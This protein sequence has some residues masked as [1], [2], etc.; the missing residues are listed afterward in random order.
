MRRDIFRGLFWQG[1]TTLAARGLR[2]VSI[3]ILAG[4]LEPVHFGIFASLYVFIDG[5]YLIQGFGL[6]QALI[7]SRSDPEA[8]ADTAFWLTAAFGLAATLVAVAAA[9]AV[10]AFYREPGVAGPFTGLAFVLLLHALRVV[11]LRR[12]EKQLDFRAKLLP[13]ALGALTFL[14]V[15][16]LLARAGAG[17]WSF[18]AG[19][20]ASAAVETAGFWILSPWRP[21]L[22]FDRPVARDL[23][24]FGLPV[25][26]GA[27]LVYLFQ[28]IDR[29]ALGRLVG[30]EG[31]GPYAFALSLA[32]LPATIGSTVVNTVMMPSYAALDDRDRRRALFLRSAT[33]VGGA[34]VG[35]AAIVVALGPYCLRAAYGDKW[36]AA[37]LPLALLSV[38]SIGRALAL[39]VGEALVGIGQPRAYRRMNLVQLGVALPLIGLG[40]KLAGPAGV[41]VAM[42]LASFAALGYGWRAAGGPL[43][44]SFRDLGRSLTPSLGLGLVLAAV[45]VAG[46]RVLPR[47]E[48]LD[49]GLGLC[50]VAGLVF[51]A[52]W[53]ALEPAV[54]AEISR[55]A[56]RGGKTA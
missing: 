56:A 23:L 52:A 48:R 53:S 37:V 51:G 43:G 47:P 31:L 9:P 6:G 21:G 41:A 14:V 2:Y 17:V 18:V 44:V 38:G 35:F 15:S 25:M 36:D 19:V 45:G 54:R 22:R 55:L 16:V 49:A 46:G 50:V 12:L 42:G 32:S 7:V 8:V 24:A 5:L 28:G 4:L 40:L 27:V 30:P 13:T 34:A 11:P 20:V 1:S 33:L 3:L 29:V 10:E 26:G 39:L